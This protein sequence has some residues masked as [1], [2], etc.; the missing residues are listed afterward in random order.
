M[1]VKGV[2]GVITVVSHECHDVT[3]LFNIQSQ[4]Q[5][6]IKSNTTLPLW[7]ESSATI[8][9]GVGWGVE[10]GGVGIKCGQSAVS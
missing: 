7:G 3:S 4:Q 2:T 6:N 10:G 5:Q 9:E 1:L 8:V